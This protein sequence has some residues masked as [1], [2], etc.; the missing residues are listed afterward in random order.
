VRRASR[1]LGL[2]AVSAAVLVTAVAPG[3][4]GADPPRSALLLSFN[5]ANYRI[6]PDTGATTQG[7]VTGMDAVPSPKGDR[8][9]YTRDVGP[10]IPYWDGT[11]HDTRDLLTA[12]PD[13]TDE[14]LVL[15]GGT[16]STAF[17]TPDWSPDGRRIAFFAA[18]DPG[19]GLRGLAV[20][21]AD[22]GGLRSLDRLGF[23]GTFSPD[24]KQ[25]AYAR[26][27]ELWVLDVATGATRA[28]TAGAEVA[29]GPPDWSP[30]GKRI[31]FTS[32]YSLLAVAAKGGPVTE[33]VR[34]GTPFSVSSPRTPVFAPDG[35]RVAYAA[36]VSDPNDPMQTQDPAVLV[37]DVA[38]GEPVVLA[39]QA[40]DLTDWVRA[41]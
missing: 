9:A 10:C 40:G 26:Q 24:G 3:P 11:C 18:S 21:N 28:L 34:W 5:L 15:S 4:A 29:A 31:V 1:R 7:P 17:S 12:N 22:G 30:D 25:I 36:Y 2:A 16:E 39:Q 20:V 13:G 37:L 32:Y 27:G 8:V 41:G 19:G 35:T 23:A 38:R 6:D 14:R 33:L